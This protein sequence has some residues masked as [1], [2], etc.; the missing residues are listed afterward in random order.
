[1]WNVVCCQH[2]NEVSVEQFKT[3]DHV[4]DLFSILHKLFLPAF[5]RLVCSTASQDNDVVA[6]IRQ[7]WCEVL[8]CELTGTHLAHLY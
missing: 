3:E 6:T 8:S 2:L 7:S 4:D 5:Y 1:M